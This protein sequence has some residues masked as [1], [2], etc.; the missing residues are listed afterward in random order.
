VT[1]LAIWATE[2]E[3]QGYATSDDPSNGV[4]DASEPVGRHVVLVAAA[5]IKPRRVRWLWDGRLALGTLG[6]LAGREG[7]GK[8]SL[9]YWLAAQISRGIL[10]GEFIGTDQHCA[11]LSA[12]ISDAMRRSTESPDEKSA[13]AEAADWLDDY[14]CANG[15]SAASAD[16]KREG[17]KAG[18]SQDCVK[19]AK[20]RLR[21]AVH[22]SG[23]PR[24]T[25]W[26]FASESRPDAQS[27]QQSEQPP[28]GESLTPVFH[29]VCV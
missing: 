24:R 4:V 11:G 7:L 6:L 12:T 28:R 25:Y 2:Y 20:G 16:I 23:F 22:S 1:A 15:G 21:L 9:G 13:T 3:R 10:P 26:S 18:H 14:L 17:V 5:D 27:A 8:S 19:R 29:E